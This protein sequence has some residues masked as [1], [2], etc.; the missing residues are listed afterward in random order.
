MRNIIF[1]LKIVIITSLLLLIFGCK[2]EGYFG[3]TV[4]I[5]ASK[6]DDPQFNTTGAVLDYRDT[7]TY[8]SHQ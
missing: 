5:T 1:I 4:I 8:R 3:P 7:T 2:R 6:C